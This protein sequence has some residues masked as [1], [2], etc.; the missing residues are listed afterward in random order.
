MITA[1]KK[2]LQL[3]EM[4]THQNIDGDNIGMISARVM[5]GCPAMSECFELAGRNP[6]A[7]MQFNN[8]HQNMFTIAEFSGYNVKKMREMFGDLY[9]KAIAEQR[10]FDI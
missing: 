9:I 10:E 6:D 1:T 3:N 7:C 8:R 4:A 2:A 5:M